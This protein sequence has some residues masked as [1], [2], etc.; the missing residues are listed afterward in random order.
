LGQLPVD[1]SDTDKQTP[2]TVTGLLDQPE[3]GRARSVTMTRLFEDLLF[4]G[5]AWWRITETHWNGFPSRIERLKPR[6]VTVD[7]ETG[8]VF[9]KGRHVPDSQLVRFDSPNDPLLV[10][11]GRAI[12]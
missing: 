4:E 3:K 1:V 12:R 8:R 11:G 7:T 2:A 5:I 9:H 10:A 6:E